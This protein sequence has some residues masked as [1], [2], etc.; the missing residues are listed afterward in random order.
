MVII[1]DN[2]ETNFRI[3]L[4][5]SFCIVMKKKIKNDW[6]LFVNFYK[7]IWIFVLRMYYWKSIYS[8]NIQRKRQREKENKDKSK[9]S[10]H[11]SNYKIIDEK[12]GVIKYNMNNKLQYIIFLSK[13]LKRS[14]ILKN[15]WRFEKFYLF[16]YF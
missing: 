4:K 5:R 11:V 10:L 15:V 16:Y 7:A 6:K 13:I 3:Y 14:L 8:K 9:I 12:S 2:I 1:S